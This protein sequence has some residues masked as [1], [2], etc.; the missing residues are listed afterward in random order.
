MSF[1]L[2]AEGTAILKHLLV[3]PGTTQKFKGQLLV[4]Y[5]STQYIREDVSSNPTTPVSYTHL[6]EEVE[7]NNGMLECKNYKHVL[8]LLP[9]I[10]F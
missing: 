2:H 6:L 5:L 1:S 10:I 4:E 7:C 9:C 3:P 8:C